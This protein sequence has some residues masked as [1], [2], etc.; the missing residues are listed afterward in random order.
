MKVLLPENGSENRVEAFIS[1]ADAKDMPLR[2][3]GWQFSWKNLYRTEG[4][5]FFK[6]AR[7]HSLGQIEGLIMLTL[8][9]QEMLYMNAIEIA[10]QNYGS[11]GRLEN[12]AGCLLGFACY[13][14]FE[15]GKEHY[16]GFL[17]FDSKTRLIKLYE[18]KYGATRAM[19]Q[20]MF[21]SPAAGKKLMRKY[22]NIG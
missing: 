5:F 2:K 6:I 11:A 1:V 18:T 17:T 13:K 10:P 16:L 7:I 15:I 21:F 8:I 4:A 19:G 20:K 22:L 14:S 3:D 9:N 12:V